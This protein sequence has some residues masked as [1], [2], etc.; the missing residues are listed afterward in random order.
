MPQAQ[1]LSIYP[2]CHSSNH[3]S[4]L[5]SVW[6]FFNSN[7]NSALLLTGNWEIFANFLTF[8]K[9]GGGRLTLDDI[10]FIST[11]IKVIVWIM[12]F[13]F[14]TNLELKGLLFVSGCGMQC[15]NKPVAF[16]DWIPRRKWWRTYVY[17]CHSDSHQ[18]AGSGWADH[19]ARWLPPLLCRLGH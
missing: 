10:S 16:R 19:T 7:T 6:Q 18:M 2:L 13:F 14:Y 8:S 9:Q 11:G 3:Q 12:Q 15:E 1:N 4:Y 5:Y 17:K